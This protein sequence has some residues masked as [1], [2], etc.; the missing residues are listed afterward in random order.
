[1]QY[2][3]GTFSPEQIEANSKAM[4]SEIHRLLLYKDSNVNDVI[5]NSDIEFKSYFENL[6]FRFG[7]LNDLLGQP[8]CMVP[9]MCTLQSALTYVF[10]DNYNYKK[11]RGM[12]LDVHGYI[13]QIFKEV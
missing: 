2:M 5:F 13:S 7:G 6:L 3:Y 10:S 12:I 1:M 8:D 4:H 11:Y 9:L